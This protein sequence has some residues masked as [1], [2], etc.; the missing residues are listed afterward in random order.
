MD[1][2]IFQ[3][4]VWNKGLTWCFAV[5]EEYRLTVFWNR[6]PK[7][8]NSPKRAGLKGWARNVTMKTFLIEI[9]IKYYPENP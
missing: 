8:V 4:V 7:D 1:R 6:V 9:F 2:N 5:W 3:S